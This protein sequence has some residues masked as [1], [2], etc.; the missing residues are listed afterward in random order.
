MRNLS[1]KILRFLLKED[2][3]SAVEYAV[4]LLLMFLAF[5][6]AV[7]VL[8]QATATSFTESSNSISEAMNP[9]R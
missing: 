4:A 1:E 9:G 7:G 5:L 6:T 2:G 8:G 3:A